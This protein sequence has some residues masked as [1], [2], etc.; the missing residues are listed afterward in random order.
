MKILGSELSRYTIFAG[1]AFL[2]DYSL[3]YILTDWVG[4]HYLLSATLSFSVGLIAN[5]IFCISWV[6]RHRAYSSVRLEFMIFFAVGVGGLV[7]ND[8]ILAICTPLLNGNYML[9]KIG[10]VVFVFL[11]N[12]FMRR[13]LLFVPRDITAGG[14]KYHCL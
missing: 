3:L 1:L 2:V 13:K 12:F 6:F 4:L 7:L 14:K 9:A 5:Y 8:I 11:W 10:A